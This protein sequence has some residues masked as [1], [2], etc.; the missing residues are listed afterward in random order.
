M[1]PDRGR[2]KTFNGESD[3]SG[4]TDSRVRVVVDHT[5]KINKVKDLALIFDQCFYLIII[6]TSFTVKNI[7]SKRFSTYFS[8]TS[9]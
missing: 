4:I 9:I 5:A 8:F 7:L 1:F 2:V 3:T 6:K